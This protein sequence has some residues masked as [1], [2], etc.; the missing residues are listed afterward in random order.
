MQENDFRNWLSNKYDND[1]TVNSRMNNCLRVE[2]SEGDLDTHFQ[3]DECRALL[4]RLVYTADDE[5]HHR[6]PLHN[7]PIDGNIRD[8]TSTLKHAVNLYV[9][10]KRA[11]APARAAVEQELAQTAVLAVVFNEWLRNPKT[12]KT[13]YKILAAVSADAKDYD[14]DLSIPGKLEILFAYQFENY[15]KCEKA[16]QVIHKLLEQYKE[17]GEWFVLGDDQLAL[18][19]LICEST[20]GGTLITK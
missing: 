7:I 17:N 5:K 15:E 20:L 13:P 2:Q 8:G 9:E 10:F 3:N 18:I 11:G 6:R 14:I 1:G 16:E 12:G 4:N 19:K